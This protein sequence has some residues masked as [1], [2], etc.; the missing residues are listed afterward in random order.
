MAEIS[1]R[2]NGS[3][4]KVSVAPET[5]LLWVLRD[6]SFASRWKKRH[7]NRRSLRKWAH[8]TAEGMDCRRGT[9]MRLLPDGADHGRG[10][11]AG[12]ESPSLGRRDNPNHDGE[13]LPVRHL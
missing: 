11:D 5:P 12:K 9:A 10:G 4:R 7:Y 6:T 8:R 13:Y 2:V 1:L 3:E